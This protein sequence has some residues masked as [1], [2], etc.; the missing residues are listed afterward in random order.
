MTRLVFS[1]TGMFIEEITDLETIKTELPIKHISNLNIKNINP[2]GY[3]DVEVTL[4]IDEID[5]E[6]STVSK[7][8][9]KAKE[10]LR[11][12]LGQET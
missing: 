9:I 1:P 3:I 4:M 11:D 7:R 5:V 2:K 10:E 12:K 6:Y 8:R